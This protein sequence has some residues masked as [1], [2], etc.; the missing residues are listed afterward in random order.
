MTKFTVGNIGTGL[1][2]IILLTLIVITDS[3]FQ[4]PEAK[5][6]PCKQVLGTISAL[7]FIIGIITV[8]FGTLVPYFLSLRPKDIREE[9]ADE[10][11]PTHGTLPKGFDNQK[12]KSVFHD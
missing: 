10:G 4:C 7:G 5:D 8:V 6:D 11:G 2:G 3:T 9:L 1:A 12:E